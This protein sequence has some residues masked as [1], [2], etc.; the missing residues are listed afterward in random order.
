MKDVDK[1]HPTCPK[2]LSVVYRYEMVGVRYTFPHYEV[3]ETVGIR[4]CLTCLRALL[5][6]TDAILMEVDNC[7]DIKWLIKL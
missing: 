4:C 2:C 5:R 6:Y 3:G 1:A 7:D